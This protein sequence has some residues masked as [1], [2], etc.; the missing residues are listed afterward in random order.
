MID[1]AGFETFD[2]EGA[3]LGNLFDRLSPLEALG[4][5]P[6]GDFRVEPGGGS[7]PAVVFYLG[8]ALGLTALGFGLAWSLRR[9]ER[10]LVAA[11]AAASALWL[12]SLLA[13]TP[14]QES[15][16]LVL[17]APLVALVCV[18]ALLARPGGLFATAYCLAAAGSAALVL[19]NGPVGPREYSP[20]LAELRPKLL[21]DGSVLVLAP[22]ELL[23]EQ[24]GRDYLVWELRGNRVCVEARGASDAPPRR[25]IA[26]E[27]VIATGDA[28]EPEEVLRNRS[29][30]SGPGPCPLIPDGARADPAV[31][32]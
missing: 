24:H 8:A 13:G 14:Y 26:S 29:T 22:A 23:A 31:D 9:G 21:G 10:A 28:V 27:V 15:K 7:V 4:P 1:F 32:G 6:S 19:V 18:K 25:G 30:A 12:F 3:G 17:A 5:W 11:L 20:V 16:A 2:P